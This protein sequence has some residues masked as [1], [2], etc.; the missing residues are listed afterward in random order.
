MSLT[1]GIRRSKVT[2][3]E[4]ILTPEWERWFSVDLLN[5][6][7]NTTPMLIPGPFANDAAAAAAGIALQQLYHD[8]SGVTHVRIV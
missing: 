2:T 8:A 6:V 4:R 3:T 5:A 7:N 1:F